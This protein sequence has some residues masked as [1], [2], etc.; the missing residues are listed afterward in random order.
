LLIDPI[1]LLRCRSNAENVGDWN[2]SVKLAGSGDMIR[3]VNEKADQQLANLC[4]RQAAWVGR[5]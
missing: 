2:I 5:E 1:A 4:V 3:D